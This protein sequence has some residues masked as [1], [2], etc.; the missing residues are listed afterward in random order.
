[1]K[2]ERS[3]LVQQNAFTLDKLVLTIDFMMPVCTAPTQVLLA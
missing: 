3:E 2:I 1:M